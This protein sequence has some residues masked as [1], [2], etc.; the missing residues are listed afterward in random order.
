MTLALP[1]PTVASTPSELMSL[2]DAAARTGRGDK[3][4]QARRWC[5]GLKPKGLSRKIDG[6]WFVSK[7]ADP[8]LADFATQEG[9]DLRQ[10][11]ELV[12]EGYSAKAIREAEGRRDLVKG[13]RDFQG[14]G[15]NS[16]GHAGQYLNRC[17]SDGTAKRLGIGKLGPET[18]LK[19]CRA[20]ER[21]GLR[22]L[23]R[24]K[25]A[26]RGETAF[27]DYAREMFIEVM[28]T[29][30]GISVRSALDQVLGFTIQRSLQDDRAWK[31]PAVRTAQLWWRENI[32]RA[33]K[34]LIAEGPH[35]MRAKALPK[36]RRDTRAD[37]AAGELL[38][39]DERTFDCMVR[40]MGERGWFRF[41]PKC[42]VW[43]DGVSGKIFWH[44]GKLANSDTILASFKQ[45]CLEMKTMP[46]EAIVDNGL[47]YKAVGGSARRNRKWDYFDTKRI[48]TA[49]GQLGVTV[50]YAM[51][52]A[53]WAKSIE[54][55][56]SG[57]KEFDRFQAGFIGGSPAERWG[58]A[59][60]LELATIDEFRERFA[61]WLKA[62]DEQPRRSEASEGL[63]PRQSF[64]QHF[65]TRPR[66]IDRDTLDILCRKTVG[67]VRVGRDGVRYQKMRY[68]TFDE[69]V[70]RIQ[71]REVW[72][73]VDPIDRDS[74]ILD[75]RDGSPLIVANVD[76]P[77]GYKSEEVRDRI[78]FQRHCE[79]TVKGYAP[80]RDYLLKTPAQ[81]IADRR[82]LA[83]ISRQIPDSQLPPKPQLV[84][85]EMVRPDVAAAAVEIKRAAG[86]EAL[87][88]LSGVDAAAE[89]VN[90][91][92]P[93]TLKDL[94]DMTSFEDETED[95]P[96]RRVS[97]SELGALTEA[98]AYAP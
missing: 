98:T 67:P 12:R 34:I 89:A 27:G 41:R 43:R 15:A 57:L 40:E 8:R 91:P 62:Y 72:M 38:I 55:T 52:R 5:E 33:A 92:R 42:T 11:G 61:A 25:C 49:F 26:G 21:E 66:R 78:A 17:R 4:R 2:G 84:S 28:Q 97:L 30:H 54:S 44:I 65:T 59:N 20:Y 56:F 32:P 94:G 16:E 1:V 69:A 96:V 73:L 85:V 51:P 87:R 3:P 64:E 76:H 18:F 13:F 14:Y 19:L 58:K 46:R 48:E 45:A 7:H 88:R 71:G 24:R 60:I 74:V 70:F 22:A 68:G 31:V 36:I 37:F 29:G 93:I 47:D 63:S 39:G 6:K 90:R 50:H 80:A 75:R 9:K 35:K 53:P 81:Q 86:A 83:A 82:R 10:L 79:K 23:V 95:A 77:L